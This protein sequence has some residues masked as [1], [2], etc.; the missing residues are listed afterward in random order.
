MVKENDG[1]NL[2]LNLYGS[3]ILEQNMAHGL[4]D[5]QAPFTIRNN[6]D[7]SMVQEATARKPIP[8]FL[9]K[10]ERKLHLDEYQPSKHKL[11]P[12][13]QVSHSREPYTN[14]WLKL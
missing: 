8:N 6:A 10:K 2:I 1:A 12:S 3:R 4:L 13:N 11:L 9:L 5:M 14:T 7:A